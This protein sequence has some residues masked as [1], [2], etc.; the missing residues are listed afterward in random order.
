MFPAQ[1]ARGF[2]PAYPEPYV[3]NQNLLCSY[4]QDYFG[5]NTSMLGALYAP[6][7]NS[8]VSPWVWQWNEWIRYQ[9]VCDSPYSPSPPGI[10][11]ENHP[12]Q[13]SFTHYSYTAN[14]TQPRVQPTYAVDQ[15]PSASSRVVG[16]PVSNTNR[17][18]IA[19]PRP[20]HPLPKWIDMTEWEDDEDEERTDLTPAQVNTDWEGMEWSDEEDYDEEFDVPR[21]FVPSFILSPGPEELPVPL[22]HPSSDSTPPS[23]ILASLSPEAC[24]LPQPR[25]DS[26]PYSPVST[27]SS[28]SNVPGLSRPWSSRSSSFGSIA[29]PDPEDLPR[30]DFEIYDRFEVGGFKFPQRLDHHQDWFGERDARGHARQGIGEGLC[31]VVTGGRRK[32]SESGA[33]VSG[34]RRG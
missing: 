4:A 17:L 21:R 29:S 14:I 6:A 30:P 34:H 13:G 25:F 27:V 22:F 15:A 2:A 7:S 28:R 18:G 1:Y 26:D 3:A 8:E 19:C 11:N 24:D 10:L 20:I 31:K 33:S 16:G 32:L 12:W 5:V 9:E 23:L